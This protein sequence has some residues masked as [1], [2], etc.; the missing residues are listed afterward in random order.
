MI[1]ELETVVLLT[2]MDSGVRPAARR[3][4][5]CAVIPCLVPALWMMLVSAL[6]SAQPAAA[7]RS[8]DDQP[9]GAIHGTVKDGSGSVVVGAIVTLETAAST[10]QR[11][12]I[13]DEAGSFHF[14]AVEPGNYKIAITASGFA[15]W[16]A[17]NVAVV[18]GQSQPLLSAVL[19]VAPAST[20]LDV[21]LSQHEL[22]VEQVK[23]ETKQRL[24][25]VFPHY[26]V[27]YE[28]N[29][30]PLSAAQKF[31]LGWKT[32]FDP[33]TIGLSVITAGIQQARN[34]YHEF[35]QGMEGYGKRFGADYADTVSGVIV[36]GV[37]MQSVFRQDPRYF[38]KGT[39]TV[40]RRFLYAIATAFVCKGDNGHWQPDYSDV[41]GGLAAGEISTL[42]YPA[43]SRTGL[44]L[45]HNVLLGFGGRMAGNLFEEFLFRRVTTHVPQAAASSQPILRE[46]T[47]V[48]LISVEDLSSKTAENAGPIAF[49][50]ASDIQVGGVTVANAGS[51]AS[52]Q[53]SYTSGPGG[54]G[55]AMHVGLD[56]VR[57]KVGSAD[58]PLRSNQIRGSA[59]PLEYHR[60]EDSGRIAIT[61]YVAE[62]VTVSKAQ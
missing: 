12:T 28:P 10:G 34:S 60:L 58:V 51:K 50:L 30:A 47:P 11:T 5:S 24:V 25:G 44:R 53:A 27:T 59:G 19:Q 32:I 46:G 16:T 1:R 35:G 36:G 55:E 31:Q 29:A 23:A 15:V 37:L 43:S 2:L 39:G 48:S 22:A 54:D 17:A 7:Q 61:L 40:R 8:A 62:T 13:T 9:P 33:V 14:S 6:A 49:V 52:G 38:Y 4:A 26:F 45:F 3:W 21:G 56:H 41:L 42:Y 20:K 18:S 57:L